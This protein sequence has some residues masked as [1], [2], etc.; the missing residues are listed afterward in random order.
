LALRR[1]NFNE[2]LEFFARL[3]AI[4]FS[5]SEMADLLLSKKLEFLMD[6]VF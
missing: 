1:L 2:Y 5:N 6:D 4:K 3:A